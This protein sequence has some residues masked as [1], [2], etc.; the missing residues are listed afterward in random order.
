MHFP[1]GKVFDG[2]IC[3]LGYF[4]LVE[5]GNV[6]TW[7]V[8]NLLRTTGE[9]GVPGEE[10]SASS[11]RV[12]PF[13]CNLNFVITLLFWLPLSLLPWIQLLY[14]QLSNNFFSLSSLINFLEEDVCRKI[15]FIFTTSESSLIS[16]SLCSFSTLLLVSLSTLLEFIVECL[17]RH[18]EFLEV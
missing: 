7:S 10:S 15:T 6:L 11:L 3:F 12:W 13:C 2:L 16:L 14:S 8:M 5:L 17:E 1:P 9:S 18:K 4:L